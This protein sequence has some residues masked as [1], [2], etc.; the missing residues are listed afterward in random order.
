MV[1]KRRRRME[2]RER[3]P[4]VFWDGKNYYTLNAEPGKKVYGERTVRFSGKEYRQ[5]DPRRSKMAA[6]LHAGMERFP[7]GRKDSVLY[8]GAASGTTAS[9][10]SEITK[11]EVYAVEFAPRPFRDLLSTAEKRENLMPILGNARHPEEY[12]DIVP[13][14][15]AVYQD[16]AQRDQVGIFIRNMGFFNAKR[17]ILMV[18]ARS[19][20][21]AENPKK[22]FQRVSD[23]LSEYASIDD[24]MRLEPY[25]KDHM[26]F[27]VR[28]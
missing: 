11:K 13:Q 24:A 5:W 21:V 17:G 16:I 8:L 19:I 15:N 18:K 2:M 26:A 6:A 28:A 23:E 3:Y 20:D 7:L 14:V 9:H 10:I 4:G 27:I 25:E 12:S 1:Q 22:V